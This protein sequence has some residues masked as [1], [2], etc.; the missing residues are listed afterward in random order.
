MSRELL[1]ATIMG[2]S[3]CGNHRG[4]GQA[5]EVVTVR[6]TVRFTTVPCEYI[7][8]GATTGCSECAG[9]IADAVLASSGER[10]ERP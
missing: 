1:I 5:L 4:D 2:V 3:D 7:P 9:K 8:R 6:P 10:G